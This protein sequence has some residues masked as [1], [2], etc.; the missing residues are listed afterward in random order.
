LALE[1]RVFWS[2]KHEK[3]QPK[4]PI[5]RDHYSGIWLLGRRL[6]SVV[7]KKY[8]HLFRITDLKFQNGHLKLP[9]F[10]R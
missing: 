6:A 5:F 1:K 7:P 10:V 9:V 2:K 4:L 3:P 8:P